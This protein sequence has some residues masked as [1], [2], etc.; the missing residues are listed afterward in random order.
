M[1]S[2]EIECDFANNDCVGLDHLSFMRLWRSDKGTQ[3]FID[4]KY[5][6]VSS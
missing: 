1:N 3:T 5:D 6:S 4:G 2:S